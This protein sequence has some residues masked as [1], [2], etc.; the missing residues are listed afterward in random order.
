MASPSGGY[1]AG[2]PRK[3]AYGKRKRGILD[4]RPAPAASP[5]GG[6]AHSPSR[7]ARRAAAPAGPAAARACARARA[8]RAPALDPRVVAREQHVGHRETR[9]TRAAACSADSRGGRPGRIRRSSDS[10]GPDDSRDQPRDRLRQRERRRLAARKHEVARARSPRRRGRARA[11]VRR[12]P[13]SARRRAAGAAARR[14]RRGR[15]LVEAAPRPGVSRTV[16]A[17]GSPAARAAPRSPP[18]RPEPS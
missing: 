14:E 11:P 7:R 9:G 18:R 6:A 1:L 5:A 13:R 4:D 8:A 16:Q 15:V 2:I 3:A 10:A 12:S 17:R